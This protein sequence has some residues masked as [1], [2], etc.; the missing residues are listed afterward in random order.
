[1][2]SKRRRDLVKLI[3]SIIAGTT[4]WMSS[5]GLAATLRQVKKVT[6]NDYP[7]KIQLLLDLDGPVQHK[8]FSL[9]SPE[10][11]VIDLNGA[12][13]NTRLPAIAVNDLL[14]DV[15][16]GVRAGND[17]RFV[18]NTQGAVSPRVQLLPP[19][20]GKGY[21]L[22]VDVYRQVARL[23]GDSN[24]PQRK[25]LKEP[26]AQRKPVQDSRL[27][28]VVVVID[29]G[30]GGKDPGAVGSK[31]T[32]E[33]DIVLSVARR[34][35][36]RLKK[37]KGVRPIMVRNKDT[38]VPLRNRLKKA[39]DVKADIFV[40]LHADGFKDPRAAGSSVYVLST[41]GAS[42]EAARWLANKENSADLVGGIDLGTHNEQVRNVLLDLH[43]SHTI[44][45]SIVLAK[46]VLGRLGKVSHLHKKHV[47]RAGF[48]VLKSP[49]IPSLLVE[50]AFITN[51]REEAKL[52]TA[53]Y[54]EKM[55]SAV[56]HGVMQ[57]FKHQA[58][59]GTV[60][61]AINSRKLS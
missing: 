32:R 12:K 23:P 3:G 43:Q 17:L 34:L 55:A 40:S 30:H 57:Y 4:P 36:S 25:A 11:I 53:D 26:V 54:Q 22:A 42:S 9:S 58:P 13:F 60:L 50:T 49:D 1:M 33:K 61:S 6:V 35:Y 44:E 19:S 8:L 41:K 21:R 51:P 28:D 52:R 10:R 47:E 45:S 15:R 56:H 20:G 27:R 39:R 59:P 18:M 37:Q 2:Y 46:N 14:K 5:V 7:E 24:Q 31:G 16:V 29:A 48:V 38:F